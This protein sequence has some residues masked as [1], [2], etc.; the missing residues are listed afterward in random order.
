MEKGMRF[1]IMDHTGHTTVV[2]DKADRVS[3][4][5]AERRF[6]ELTGSGFRAAELSSGHEGRLIGTFDPNVESL[7]F[8]PPLQGG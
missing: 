5:D 7:L 4:E 2:F 1:Q 6:K 3:M 8:V